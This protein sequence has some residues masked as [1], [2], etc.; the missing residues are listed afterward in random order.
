MMMKQT[1]CRPLKKL[2]L[3]GKD[4]TGNGW[5]GA[6][7]G[8]REHKG[9]DY[10]GNPGDEVFA[11]ASGKIR[12]GR[13]YSNPSKSEFTLVEIKNKTY[14]IKQ[15]YVKP[16]V[17]NGDIVKCGQTIGILQAIGDFYGDGMPNHCHVGIWKNGLLTDPEPIIK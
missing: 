15:M 4:P 7:R 14:T 1:I 9:V 5:Y 2:K 8:S 10:L 16:I 17:K 11:C 6:S 12:I 13:V 3:R